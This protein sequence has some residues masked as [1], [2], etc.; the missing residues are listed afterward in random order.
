MGAE[1]FTGLGTGRGQAGAVDVGTVDADAGVSQ[2]RVCQRQGW[3]DHVRAQQR[4]AGRGI[5]DVEGLDGERA[6]GPD[7]QVHGAAGF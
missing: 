5:E 2:Q 4:T 6:V 7:R 1:E 3:G